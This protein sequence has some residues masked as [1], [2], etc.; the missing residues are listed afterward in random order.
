MAGVLVAALYLGT[1]IPAAWATTR[2]NRDLSRRVEQ[3]T[4]GVAE[5]RRMYPAQLI[6]LVGVDTALFEGGMVHDPFRLFGVRNVYLTASSEQLI[7]PSPDT[8]G[9]L[10]FTLPPAAMRRALAG[11]QAVV[12]Q[13]SGDVLKNV[14]RSFAGG[15]SPNEEWKP[16][17]RVD[18]A[19]QVFA[20]QLGPTWHEAEERHRWMPERATVR[21]AGP[22]SPGQKLHLNGLAPEQLVKTGP[23]E[24]TVAVDG[25]PLSTVTL[26]AA[27]PFEWSFALPAACVGAREI[28][29]AVEASRT[30][31]P[32]GD[33]R[34]LSLAFGT[35]TIR[36][37]GHD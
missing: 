28:E 32:P 9:V 21:L 31:S 4:L 26:R 23:V 16:D 19:L 24:V 17:R 5:L 18:V 25:K 27:G 15:M 20:R 14:T 6:V 29:I 30:F 33:A 12:Y 7:N 3:L 11:D 36:N 1:S 22:A 34:R 8:K 13:V 10:E 35:F 2:S 37:G